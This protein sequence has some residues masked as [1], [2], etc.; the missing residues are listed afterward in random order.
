MADRAPSKFT[1]VRILIRI[2]RSIEAN[3]TPIINITIATN[4]LGSQMA[5]IIGEV[6]RWAIIIFTFLAALSQLGVAT[7]L[8]RILFTGFVAMIAL[9]GGLAFGFGGKDTA[10]KILKKFLDRILG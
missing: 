10:E 4:I 3:T 6:A 1:V 9:A 5:Q 7:D 2:L 8:I